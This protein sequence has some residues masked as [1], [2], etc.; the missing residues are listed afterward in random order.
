MAAA[1]E[2]TAPSAKDRARIP[3]RLRLK[4]WWEGYELEV[5]DKTRARRRTSAG[6]EEAAEEVITFE[7][8]GDAHRELMQAV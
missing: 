5:H 4:A 3:F 7:R 2:A 8:W 1:R 6:P